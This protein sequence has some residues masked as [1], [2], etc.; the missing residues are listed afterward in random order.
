MYNLSRLDPSYISNA[1]RFID[2]AKNHF[3]RTKKKHINCPYMDCKNIVVF[4]DT[5]WIISHLVYR[6]FM[7][8]YMIWTKH[9]DGSSFPYT[10]RNPANING[11]F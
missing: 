4:D 11:E 8:D 7:K 2:A 1:H 6:G 10:F 5:E 9:V 3:W